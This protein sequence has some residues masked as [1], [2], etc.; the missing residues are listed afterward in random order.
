MTP[1]TL[2]PPFFQLHHY[3]LVTS[4]NDLIRDLV[5]Q[6]KGQDGLIV[7]ADQQTAGRGRRGR[8]WVS[9]VGNLYVSMLVE[10]MPEQSLQ[11]VAQIG[12]LTSLSMAVAI[13]YLL[14][15]PKI[16]QIKWPNDLLINK[17]KCAGILLE[18][19]PPENLNDPFFI[20]V[21]IGVNIATFPLNLPYL[22][23]SL[24]AAQGGNEISLSKLLKQF[25]EDFLPRLENWRAGNFVD[26]RKEWLEYACGIGEEILVH[27]P[28]ET[29]AGIFMD[30][31]E[32]GQLLLKNDA[33]IR[34][35]SVGDVFFPNIRI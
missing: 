24:Q 25:L 33:G 14:G 3:P 22:A 13:N 34:K 10:K 17:K 16:V 20:I 28:S 32:Q 23:T 27:L 19:L 5:K 31:N 21:G 30:L 4:T 15:K 29:V 35:I 26:I 11:E 2:L 18:T 12:F 9:P 6:G 1:I 7:Q 8:T